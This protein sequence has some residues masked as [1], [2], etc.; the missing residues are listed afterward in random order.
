MASRMINF[1]K[2]I[3]GPDQKGFL[4]DG[5]IEENTRLAYDLMQYYKKT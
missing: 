4:K 5:Y 2:E 1:L 3:I